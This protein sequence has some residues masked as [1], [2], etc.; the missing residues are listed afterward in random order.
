MCWFH[1]P[2]G[3][4]NFQKSNRWFRV[5]NNA[6]AVVLEN[7]FQV[8]DQSPR[9]LLSPFLYVLS[10]LNEIMGFV[11]YLLDDLEI[12]NPSGWV[13]EFGFFFQ[14]DAFGRVLEA[15]ERGSRVAAKPSLP[16]VM[17]ICSF[18]WLQI[19][20]DD[21]EI[22]HFCLK[23]KHKRG[24]RETECLWDTRFLMLYRHPELVLQSK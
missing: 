3:C 10:I 14:K 5:A 11:K 8:Q 18:A 1:N 13:P 22:Y 15:A 21:L 4:F 16:I 17:L 23:I 7:R 24:T 9:E 6:R 2:R 19:S 12:Y 20:M